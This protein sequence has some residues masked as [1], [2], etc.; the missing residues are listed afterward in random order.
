MQEKFL[1]PCQVVC[2]AIPSGV[3]YHAW[4]RANDWLQILVDEGSS[5]ARPYLSS[6]PPRFLNIDVWRAGGMRCHVQHP[7]LL[8][9]WA[10]Q[11]II[12]LCTTSR[13]FMAEGDFN[14]HWK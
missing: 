12:I 3:V 6:F 10:V 9:G 7:E 11:S 8:V 4:I 5:W 14:S 2:Y 1:G 13:T